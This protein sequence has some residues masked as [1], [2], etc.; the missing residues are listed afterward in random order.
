MIENLRDVPIKSLEY[1]A[2]AISGHRWRVLLSSRSKYQVT[3]VLKSKTLVLDPDRTFLFDLALAALC[4]EAEDWLADL[5]GTTESDRNRQLTRK[6]RQILIPKQQTNLMN[7]YRRLSSNLRNRY[8][9]GRTLAGFHVTENQAAWSSLRRGASL[10]GLTLEM[11]GGVELQGIEKDGRA[12]VRAIRR[13]EIEWE[14]LSGLEEFAVATVP[15]SIS[16]VQIQDMESIERY[17]SDAEVV[18]SM[19]GFYGCLQ[20]KSE[21]LEERLPR[22]ELRAQGVYLDDARL[23]EAAV[24][25]KR[26]VPARIFRRKSSNV[27]PKF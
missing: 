15:F 26:G 7:R 12:F 9:P 4:G 2:L 22:G 10:A 18:D 5:A 24:S 19:N 21:S 1:F 23:V 27:Q 25:A 20:R 11:I 8:L 14:V 16:N 3:V 13:G 17:L 6:A